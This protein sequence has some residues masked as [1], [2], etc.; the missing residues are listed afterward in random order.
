MKRRTLIGAAVS[1]AAAAL[2]PRRARAGEPIRPPGALKP[3]DFERA[4]IGCYRCA[5][6][7]P[8]LAIQFPPRL[9]LEEAVPYVDTRA[10]GCVLCMQC[11][12][13]CPTGALQPIAARSEVIA[14]EVRMG[15][16][17]LHRD[18]CLPWSGTGNCRLCH[19]V[20]PYADRAVEL[21]GPQLGPLFHPDACVGCGLCEEACPSEARAIRI[22]PGGGK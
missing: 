7:C 18:R 11:T 16:P 10:R 20:C 8:P 21:V 4:C 17:Q 15:V 12:N 9:G 3:G 14:V 2:V 5:E 6:V 22:V 13:V 19:E 1:A